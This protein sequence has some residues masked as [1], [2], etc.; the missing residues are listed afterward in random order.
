MMLEEELQES[1]RGRKE[2]RQKSSRCSRER[3]D[4]DDGWG[5]RRMRLHAQTEVVRKMHIESEVKLSYL[6]THSAAAGEE[7]VERQ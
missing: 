7:E 1:K 4:D 5:Q 3:E 6:R 2:E